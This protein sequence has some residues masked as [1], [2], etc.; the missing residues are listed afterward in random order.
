M[1]WR[2]C[3]TLGAIGQ[4]DGIGPRSTRVSPDAHSAM[5][6]CGDVALAQC[7]ATWL[8]RRATCLGFTCSLF[9]P[10]PCKPCLARICPASAHIDAVFERL[11]D[12]IELLGRC[13]ER[14]ACAGV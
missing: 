3:A 14:V 5:A 9:E 12:F 11:A 8:A 6:K 7:P 2:T 10:T 4:R 1:A 13:S